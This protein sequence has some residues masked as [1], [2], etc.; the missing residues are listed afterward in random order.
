MKNF[1]FVTTFAVT[2]PRVRTFL[3]NICLSPLGLVDF[4]VRSQL[5]ATFED[6]VEGAET[7]FEMKLEQV[8][9]DD[10][11]HQISFM[12]VMNP[13]F[14]NGGKTIEVQLSDKYTARQNLWED[15]CCAS[16]FFLE[17]DDSSMPEDEEEG[18]EADIPAT[19]PAQWMF[20]YEIYWSEDAIEFTKNGEY[21]FEPASIS[22]NSMSST[23]H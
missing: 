13:K 12:S 5:Y 15:N 7:D 10:E 4:K 14:A 22:Y 23:Y 2:H 21:I 9:D 17:G 3:D 20:K 18:E 1:Y 11:D 16:L 19:G 6:A 8:Y